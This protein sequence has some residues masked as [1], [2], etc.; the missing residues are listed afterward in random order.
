MELLAEEERERT[1][2]IVAFDNGFMTQENDTV[3][4]DTRYG[5]TGAT[6]CERKGHSACPISFL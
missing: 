4:R 2:P 3:C 1:T 6:W 5:Q